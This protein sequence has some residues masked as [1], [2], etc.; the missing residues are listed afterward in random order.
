LLDGVIEREL[1][2]VRAEAAADVERI[3]S[4]SVNYAST[5]ARQL[6]AVDEALKRNRG[7]VRYDIQSFVLS[8]DGV[9]VHFVRAEWMA[10]GRQG[11]AVSLW[12]RGSDRLEIIDT[13]LRPAAWLRMFEFQGRVA[14]EHQGLVLNVF[15]RD[16][17]GWGEVL[18]AQGGYESMTLSLLKYSP[19]GFQPTGIEYGYGC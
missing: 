14:K 3:A 6:Q 13:N 17:N 11:F 5:W 12:L 10:L 9:P 7:D 16:H 15:D 8:P 4:G 1:P 18:M 19:T 2:G